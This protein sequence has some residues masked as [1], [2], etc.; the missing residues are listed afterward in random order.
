MIV[1]KGFPSLSQLYSSRLTRSWRVVSEALGSERYILDYV[2]F[3]EKVGEIGA[4][5]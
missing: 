4:P 2:N 1:P 5:R 3:H